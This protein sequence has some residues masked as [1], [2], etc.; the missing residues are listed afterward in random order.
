MNYQNGCSSIKN[1]MNVMELLVEDE[2]RH[3][4]KKLS[5]RHAELLQVGEIIAYALNQLPSLYATTTRGWDYQ[6]KQ[7]RQKYAALITQAVQ[8]AINAVLRDPIMSAIAL[9]VQ[10][11]VSLRNIL[12]EIRV[13]LQ[14]QHLEWKDVPQSIERL[15]YDRIHYHQLANPVEASALMDLGAYHLEY[16]DHRKI[17]PLL[18]QAHSSVINRMGEEWS[19]PLY[20]R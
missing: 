14:D 7:G 12:Y 11:P 15:F 6:V 20:T 2:V 19:N 16:G 3:Q 13:L 18:E 10:I 4:V 8:C 1:Y 17:K 5:K 9:E